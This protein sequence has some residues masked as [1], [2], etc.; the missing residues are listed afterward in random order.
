[1]PTLPRSFK[2]ALPACLE[3]NLPFIPER[4]VVNGASL[5]ELI[6]SIPISNAKVER[7]FSLMNRVKTDSRAALS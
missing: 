2:I 6:F 3:T 4:S 7:L 1:M 5:V